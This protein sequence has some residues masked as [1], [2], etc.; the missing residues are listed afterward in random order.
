MDHIKEGINLRAYAQKDPLTEYKRESFN[1]FESMRFEIKKAIIQNIFTVRLYTQEEIEEIQ[2]RHQEELER[3][4]R[5][6]QASLDT[7]ENKVNSAT[8]VTRTM[9][10]VGR[11]DPCP[12][13][14]SKK[15]KHCHGA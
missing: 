7:Q 9:A 8:K 2:Q 5:E 11:N 15:F 6:H 14:S 10:K 13:G 3:K 12:C 1:L 4:L